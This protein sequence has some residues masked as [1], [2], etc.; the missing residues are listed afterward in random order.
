MNCKSARS[1]IALWV[2]NDLDEQAE[3]ALRQHVAQCS[4]CRCFRREL[5]RSIQVLQEADGSAENAPRSPDLQDS[6][7]PELDVRIAARQSAVTGRFNGWLP[8]L[9]V[10]AACLMILAFSKNTPSPFAGH[11]PDDSFEALAGGDS[12]LSR[13]VQDRM[14]GNVPD[15]TF[16]VP[17]P[18]RVRNASAERWHSANR[19]QPAYTFWNVG[20]PVEI[21]SGAWPSR[22]R[23]PGQAWPAMLPQQR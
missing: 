17:F 6:L 11:R 19:G 22:F 13:P 14:L 9:A 20:D 21:E 2:G 5:E 7:W 1:A 3:P 15:E 23:Q 4:Q 8:A 16:L 18:L 10:S 12:P